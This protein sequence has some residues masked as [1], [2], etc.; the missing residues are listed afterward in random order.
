MQIRLADPKHLFQN[1][2]CYLRQII[3]ILWGFVKG[4]KVDLLVDPK[5]NFWLCKRKIQNVYS[6]I[7]CEKKW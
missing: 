5:E 2:V 4:L 1:Q 3:E 6:N 7:R